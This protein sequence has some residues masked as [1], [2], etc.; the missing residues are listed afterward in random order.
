MPIDFDVTQ[1]GRDYYCSADGA[2]K[3]F[4]GRRVPYEGR[5]GLYNVFGGSPLQSL[6][7]SA[8]NYA[9]EF[10]FWV[11]FIAPTAACEGKNFLTLNSYDRAAFTFGF[12][13]FAAHVPEGDFVHYF[14]ALL[15]R[16]DAGDYFPDLALRNGRITRV[17]GAGAPVQLETADTTQPLMTYLNP[18][19]AGVEDAEVLAAAKFIHWTANQREVRLAQISE[20]IAAYRGFMASADAKHLIANRGA[21]Q[22]CV[23][24]DILHHG[25]GGKTAWTQIKTAMASADPFAALCAIGGSKWAGRVKTLK[26]A[27]AANPHFADRVWSSAQKDFVPR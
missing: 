14:R 9:G 23:I 11:E 10:G 2:P 18:S 3:F 7:F 22:C 27:I 5:V 17:G 20:M 6:N 19:S 25:R 8:G 13:Q 16:P 1:D 21:N 26:T 15:A 24:A 4:V 12:T